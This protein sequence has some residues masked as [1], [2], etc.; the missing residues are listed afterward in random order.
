MLIEFRVGNYRSFH[1]PQTLSLVA[2]RDRAHPDNLIPCAKENL[3][4]A[5][6]IFGAN[7]S[8]KSNLVNAIG[9]MS[10]FVRDSAKR[11]N[12]GEEIPVVP[13]RLNPKSRAEPSLFEA[14]LILNDV[15]YQYGFRASRERVHHEWLTAYPNGR[16]QHWLER[17][18][19]PE[20]KEPKWIFRGSLK[21]NGDLLRATTRANGLAL[22]RGADLNIE[23][24]IPVFTW[25]AY[26][27]RVLD[28][29]EPATKVQILQET[30]SRFQ[31]DAAFRDTA[32]R[33]VQNADVGINGLQVR[34]E[35]AELMPCYSYATPFTRR[36]ES[37]HTVP[38]TESSEMFVFEEAESSG[39]QR[40]FALLGPWLYALQIAGVLA[41]DELDCSM[42]PL[43]T[44]GLIELFQSPQWNSK[45]AQLIFATHD[46]TLMD[47]SLFR[48]DQIYLVEKNAAQASELFSLYD[49]DDKPRKGEAIQR[50]YLAGR[51]GAVPTLGATFENVE[52]P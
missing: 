27:L 2:S 50:G 4:K 21:R 34:V 25:L 41:I 8:G 10:W 30:A 44:R 32:I 6:A 45:G 52:F 13:F 37:V 49:F 12:V 19:G 46:N 15:R 5:V 1:E 48:R 16:A 11:M 14:T 39:T 28:F 36:L 31:E 33:L 38:G 47:Q 43:L 51:Y 3:L 35:M 23:E 26:E 17:Y 22:C 18:S 24:L 40:L 7:A 9:F 42:H 20:T 29:S